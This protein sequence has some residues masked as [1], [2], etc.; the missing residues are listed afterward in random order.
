MIQGIIGAII[1]IIG[2]YF[3]NRSLGLYRREEKLVWHELPFI[4]FPDRKEIGASWTFENLGNKVAQ[5]VRIVIE[6]PHKAEF[7]KVS[8]VP[9]E[10]AIDIKNIKKEGNKL[11]IEIDKIPINTTVSISA[12]LKNVNKNDEVTIS[13]LS[14]NVKGIINGVK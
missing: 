11:T 13:A 2:T 7:D 6:A 9:S 1:G 10:S 8:V 3:V 4:E 12:L 5:D 14:V